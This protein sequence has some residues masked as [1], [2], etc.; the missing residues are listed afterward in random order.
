MTLSLSESTANLPELL[1][2]QETAEYL[3]VPLPTIYYLAQ[4]GQ[5]PAV[6]IGGRWRIKRHLLDRKLDVV[7]LSLDEWAKSIIGSDS[8][9]KNGGIFIRPSNE[10]DE[11]T[12]VFVTTSAETDTRTLGLRDEFAGCVLH[13]LEQENHSMPV[14]HFTTTKSTL[15]NTLNHIRDAIREE[16]KK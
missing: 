6:Q 4:R 15:I 8:L 16:R 14:W 10:A 9:N 13:I 1:T 3:K 11:K 12:D 5:L 2:V 7:T